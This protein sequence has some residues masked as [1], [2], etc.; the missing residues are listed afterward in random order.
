MTNYEPTNLNPTDVAEPTRNDGVDV[1]VSAII[2]ADREQ[3]N[4]YLKVDLGGKIIRVLGKVPASVMVKLTVAGK[5]NDVGLFQDAILQVIIP[6]DRQDFIDFTDE[7][8][9]ST[10]TLGQIFAKI[11]EAVSGKVQ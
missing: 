10:E 11:I 8:N 7:N 3:Q 1:D 5:D 6:E 2:A 9:L 4:K